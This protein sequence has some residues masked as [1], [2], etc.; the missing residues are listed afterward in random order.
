MTTHLTV[1]FCIAIAALICAVVSAMGKC[2]E[3]VS[4]IFLC[5]FALIISIPLK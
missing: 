2:P 5:I 1:A 3:W 4:I